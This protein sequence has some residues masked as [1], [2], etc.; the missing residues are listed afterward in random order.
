MDNE[1][2]LFSIE[3]LLLNHKGSKEELKE[4]IRK[5]IKNAK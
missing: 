1:T 3:M 2:K 5:I 4:E